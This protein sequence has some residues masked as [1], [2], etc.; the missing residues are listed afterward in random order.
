MDKKDERKNNGKMF[1]FVEPTYVLICQ[2]GRCRLRLQIGYPRHGYDL[3]PRCG[4]PMSC[5]RET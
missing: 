3:C 4:S 5:R 2:N 1:T